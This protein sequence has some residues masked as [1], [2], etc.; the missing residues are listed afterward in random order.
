GAAMA[1]AKARGASVAPPPPTPAPRTVKLTAETTLHAIQ[2]GWVAVKSDHRAF[3]GP[4]FLRLPAILASDEW[5]EWLPIAAF[6]VE[7]RDEVIVVDAGETARMADPAYAA[8]DEQTG[9]FYR[10]NLR[11]AVKEAEEIGPQMRALGLPPKRAR[12]VVMTHLHSDHMGGMGWFPEAEFL[13]SARD[14][15]GHK[16]ALPCR[17]PKGIRRTPVAYDGPSL[18]A[19]EASRPVTADGVVAIVP[20]P[21]HTP[22]HQSVVISGESRRWILAGDA[23][24]STEQAE[25]EIV[26]G[27]VEDHG[28]ARRTLKTLKRQLAAGETAFLASHDPEA[29]AAL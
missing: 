21:G 25:R 3:R 24:F 20:T 2:T 4:A 13:I 26:A 16:G 11:F 28:A 8:C 9:W 17:E 7:H 12:T 5:T 6:V 1:A 10:R 29:I 27:I 23:A 19:F 15:G 18:D 22:G 14:F